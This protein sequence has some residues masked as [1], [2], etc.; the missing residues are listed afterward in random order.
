MAANLELSGLGLVFDQ[1]GKKSIKGNGN[2]DVYMYYH[3][4]GLFLLLEKRHGN[5]TRG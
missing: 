3:I 4:R 2:V 5:K 1:K